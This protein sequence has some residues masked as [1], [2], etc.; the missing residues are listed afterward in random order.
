MAKQCDMFGTKSKKAASRSHSNIKTL[1]RQLPN[2]HKKTLEVP[3]LNTKVTAQL[4]TKAV[5]TI[6][7]YGSLSEALLRT[8]TAT[9]SPEFTRLKARL[10]KAVGTHKKTA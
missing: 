7:K 3:E 8:S 6:T 10:K 4:S 9:L 1:R 2:L 5:R